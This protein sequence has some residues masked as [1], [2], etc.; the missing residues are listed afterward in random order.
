MDLNTNLFLFSGSTGTKKHSSTGITVIYPI[1]GKKKERIFLDQDPPY[2][3]KENIF[4]R[5]EKLWMMI[6]LYSSGFSC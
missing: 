1:V 5:L 6:L 4:L 3:F 2:I